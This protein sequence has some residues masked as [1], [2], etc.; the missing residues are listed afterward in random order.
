[1]KHEIHICMY[2]VAWPCRTASSLLRTLRRGDYFGE[3]SAWRN[4]RC[5]PSTVTA[6]GGDGLPCLCIDLEL[7]ASFGLESFAGLERVDQDGP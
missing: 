6:G 2:F 5:N 4:D 1:M 7:L 3:R